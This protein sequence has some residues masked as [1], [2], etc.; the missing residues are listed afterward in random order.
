M[1][2]NIDSMVSEAESR[3]RSQQGLYKQSKVPT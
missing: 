3:S 1:L 2:L